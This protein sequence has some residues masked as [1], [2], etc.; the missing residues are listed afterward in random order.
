MVRKIEFFKK[1]PNLGVIIETG[2]SKILMEKN[3]KLKNNINF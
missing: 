3:I 1:E 2:I